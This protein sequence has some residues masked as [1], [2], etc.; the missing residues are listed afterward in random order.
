MVCVEG[1]FGYPL[2][3]TGEEHFEFSHKLGR[4]LLN[5]ATAKKC[6]VIF[7]NQVRASFLVNVSTPT[8]PALGVQF[9]MQQVF[10]MSMNFATNDEEAVFRVR[11][12]KLDRWFNAYK[13]P[14]LFILQVCFVSLLIS[15]N[16]FTFSLV[17]LSVLQQI[18]LSNN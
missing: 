18:N 16:I 5:I 15:N 1:Q 10:R 2:Y 14:F 4:A 11:S 9:Y 17:V 12:L 6:L 13:T 7:V 8:V 3:E